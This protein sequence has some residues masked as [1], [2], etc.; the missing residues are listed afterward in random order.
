[1]RES[2]S[3]PANRH[4]PGGHDLG[5]LSLGKAAEEAGLSRWEFETVLV[6]AGFEALYGPR[7]SEQL[8]DEVDAARD[9]DG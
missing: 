1:M 6:D 7:T 9:I 8:T 4:V 3:W 5:E 2:A